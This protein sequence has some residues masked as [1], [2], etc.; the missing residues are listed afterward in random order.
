MQPHRGKDP[1][2]QFGPGCRLEL[3]HSQDSLAAWPVQVLDNI[4]GRLQLQYEGAPEWPNLHCFY[5]NPYLHE[6]GWA[7]QNGYE[8]KP[9]QGK[10]IS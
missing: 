3:Q 5:L 1:L 6:I 8:V 7:S 9:P 4:G 2:D 10:Y